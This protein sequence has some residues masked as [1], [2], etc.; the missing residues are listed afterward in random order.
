MKSFKEIDESRKVSTSAII[1]LRIIIGAY[2]AYVAVDLLKGYAESTIPTA[3][4]IPVCIILIVAGAFI[5]LISL[6]DMFKGRYVGGIG[7]PDRV[8]PDL[9]DE[10]VSAESIEAIVEENN[11]E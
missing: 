11:E 5:A 2:V 3:V 8:D 1:I 6:R 7:D 9:K 4:L 10:P